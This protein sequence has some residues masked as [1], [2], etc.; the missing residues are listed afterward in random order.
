MA[1]PSELHPTSSMPASPKPAAWPGAAQA[2]SGTAPFRS[3]LV[4]GRI[5]NLPTVWSNC[6]AAWLIAGAAPM[7]SFALL[8]AG[9][10][11]LYSGGMFLND[12]VDASFDRQ[13]RPERPIPLGRISRGAVLVWSLS[14]L[15]AGWLIL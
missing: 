8:I 10:T 7:K 11:C 3:L 1:S 12:A 15:A 4:L 6:L 14:L 9:A 2:H 13:F 5:S